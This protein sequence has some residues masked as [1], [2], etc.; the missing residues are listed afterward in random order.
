MIL[1]TFAH[2][3][4]SERVAF[5]H[6]YLMA[7]RD[8]MLVIGT[9]IAT[10]A[11]CFACFS[12]A[13]HLPL[14]R[15]VRPWTLRHVAGGRW[16]IELVQRFTRHPM[17]DR[18]HT[19]CSLSCGIEFY[20]TFLPFLFWVGEVRL[21]RLTTI[22]MALCIYV[23]NAVKDTVCAPRPTIG[24]KGG[25]TVVLVGRHTDVDGSGLDQ[26]YG[27]PSTHTIN[28]V[29]LA[30]YLLHW[31]NHWPAAHT[32]P[33]ASLAQAQAHYPWLFESLFVSGNIAVQLATVLAVTWCFSCG[34]ASTWA[35]S[36]VDL[37]AGLAI[38]SVPLFFIPLRIS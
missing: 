30:F 2:L 12:P 19:L 17:L 18:L 21:A 27:L 3:S 37:L 34:A 36:P 28:T 32:A 23:G 26:E 5:K 11:F 20:I 1:L 25:Y 9:T 31:V 38:G 13:L 22:F 15:L 6:G 10:M 8:M 29:C 35:H 7:T 24:S 4:G 14:R 16:V 33:T